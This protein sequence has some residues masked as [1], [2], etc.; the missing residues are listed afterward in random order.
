MPNLYKASLIITHMELT[1][2]IDDAGRGPVIGPLVL[3]GALLNPEAEEKLKALGV[4]D[5]KLLTPK[6]RESLAEEIKEI[7]LGYETVVTSADQLNEMMS[8]GINLNFIE[9]I[10]VAQ[11]INK[12]RKKVDYKPLKIIL[13]CPSINTYAW[14]DKVREFVGEGKELTYVC[15]HKADVNN[16]SVG[17][18]A[19]LAKVLRDEEIQK[20]KE[21]I[22]TDFG[23]GY[24]SDPKTVEFIRENYE[25]YKNHKIFREHWQTLQRITGKDK[26]ERAGH[27]KQ[28]K[29]F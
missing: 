4:R 16:I 29:L 27:E 23:S 18:G 22:G 24:P 19:I 26:N 20:I 15:E 8:S 2:G 1:L 9:A 11:I 28:K 25:K 7:S 5:S 3:G 13:D 17:A 6:K 21:S 14:L 12:I 10:A